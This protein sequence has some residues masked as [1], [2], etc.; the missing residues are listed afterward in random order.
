MDR[1]EIE[2]R[3]NSRTSS[4]C[5]PLLVAVLLTPKKGSLGTASLVTMHFA[6]NHEVAAFDWSLLKSCTTAAEK[7]GEDHGSR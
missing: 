6:V 2:R 4:V 7:R 1:F 5:G 3:S